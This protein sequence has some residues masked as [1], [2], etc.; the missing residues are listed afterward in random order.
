MLYVTHFTNN[1]AGSVANL[2]MLI[3][4]FDILVQPGGPVRF[5]R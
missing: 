4:T 2:S 5:M 3:D 1:A